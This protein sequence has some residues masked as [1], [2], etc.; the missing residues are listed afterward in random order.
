[1]AKIK[2][3]N[4][5][6]DWAEQLDE[7]FRYKLMWGGRGGGKTWTISDKFLTYA[8]Q[9]KMLIMCAREFLSSIEDSVKKTLEKRIADKNLN[10]YFTIYN[11]R[12]T[13]N[14]TGTI[15]KFKG[16]AR[17]IVNNKGWE[18]VDI[19]WI[20]E[21]ESIT[22]ET[23]EL[24]R[25]SVRK[26]NPPAEIWLSMNRKRR[27]DAIDQFFLSDKGPPPDSLVLNV[28]WRD[29]PFFFDNEVLVKE[30]E[31]DL[32]LRP[33]RY[34]HIWEGEPDES[35]DGMP[36]LP[37]HNLLQCV[38]AAEK[39]G[40]EPEGLKM[41]GLDI[42]DEGNDMNSYALKQGNFLMDVK[43]WKAKY[44][45]QTATRAN[46]LNQENQVIK[47]FYD[48]G[49]LGAGIKSEVSKFPTDIANG[50]YPNH[51]TFIP[52]LSNYKVQGPDKKYV[53]GKNG[54]TNND[55]FKDLGA[56]AWWNIKLRVENTIKA[57]SGLDYD[58]ER[59]FFINPNLPELPSVLSE[60]AQ[61]VYTVDNKLTINKK[62]GN[63]PSPNKADSII[64]AYSGDCKRGLKA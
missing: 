6:P 42:A 26:K 47:C 34:A 13:C 3:I 61:C 24:I 4:D 30:R 11:N 50:I 7:P 40:L 17:N 52:F 8:L 10:D 5:F 51:N 48:I 36:V 53:K 43:T 31:T 15:F 63:I 20:E 39:L 54:I 21:A 19:L 57:L 64:M 32:L 45:H 18:D 14:I 59:C 55:F 12:I 37:Y 9:R 60:L 35:V 16:L 58:P 33:E 2:I 22:E 27:T 44:L 62:P 38:G 23:W 29:N 28:N 25:P 49:G 56:Q 1:M 46:S 41:A